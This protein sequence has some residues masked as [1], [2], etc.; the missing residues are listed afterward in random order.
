MLI[1]TVKGIMRLISKHFL[2]HQVPK[3]TD[4]VFVEE[5]ILR[6]YTE[7][8]FFLIV[9]LFHTGFRCSQTGKERALVFL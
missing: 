6:N 2:D 5:K 4:A 3:R 8:S 7:N 1:Y 9:S